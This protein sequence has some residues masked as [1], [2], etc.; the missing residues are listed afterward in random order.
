M[1]NKDEIVFNFDDA[2]MSELNLD[3]LVKVD[4]VK[5]ELTVEKA[6]EDEDKERNAEYLV[7]YDKIMFEDK[8]EKTYRLGKNYSATFS[9]RS[10]DADMAV[11]RQLDK[12][13]F[14]TMHAM[15]TM[16]SVLTMS[17][18]LTALNGKS[19]K[20]MTPTDRFNYIRERSSHLIEI[21]SRKMIE[22]D[23][24]VREALEYGEEN[25]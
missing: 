22:F 5:P 23:T 11:S 6:E 16:S 18:S 1:N 2:D 14:N 4:E 19:L 20:D 12:L 7:I 10:A 24:L 25:F 8:F 21:L 9:T 17:H 13:S 15:Q 3:G